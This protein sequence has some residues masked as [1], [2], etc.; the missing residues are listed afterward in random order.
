M[1]FIHC[2]NSCTQSSLTISK[3]PWISSENWVLSSCQTQT[4]FRYSLLSVYSPGSMLSRPNPWR[5]SSQKASW[6]FKSGSPHRSSQQISQTAHSLCKWDARQKDWSTCCTGQSTRTQSTS[7]KGLDKL[8]GSFG[9]S[10][11]FSAHSR[12][13]KASRIWISL[14]SVGMSELESTWETASFSLQ[15]WSMR[16]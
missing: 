14:S 15:T 3:S 6:L 1:R 12:T 9:K 16:T 10:T 5:H 4:L 2:L 8:K 11:K 7:T 13:W